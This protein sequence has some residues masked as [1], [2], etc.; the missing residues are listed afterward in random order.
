M[1]ARSN[2]LPPDAAPTSDTEYYR[3]VLHDLIDMGAALA[4]Q[5]HDQAIT[6]AATPAITPGTQPDTKPDATIP[7]D[8]IAR[9]VRRTIALART[10]DLPALACTHAAHTQAT[11]IQ[12]ARTQAARKRILRDVEDAIQ[13][14]TAS[15][16]ASPAASPPSAEALHAE[17]LDRL[18]GPDLDA[19]ITHWPLPQIIADICRDL[20]LASALGA[21]RPWKRRTPQDIAQ[22]CAR[23][24]TDPPA[25]RPEQLRHPPPGLG[26]T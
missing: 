12:A 23:A 2:P 16:A 13:R 17:L 26:R 19:D 3:R 18:D 14:T 8:R 25:P 20:G 24:A 5:V 22:L 9:A 1:S 11:S 4:R 6:P 21:P 15:P 7:F 10:L